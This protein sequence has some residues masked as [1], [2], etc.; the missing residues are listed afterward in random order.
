MIDV[1]RICPKIR[2]LGQK[3]SQEKSLCVLRRDSFYSR[4][5]P[6]L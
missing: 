6:G 1:E 4:I 3:R 5:R 2:L